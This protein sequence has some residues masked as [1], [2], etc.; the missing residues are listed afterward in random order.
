MNGMKKIIAMFRL[1]RF[2]DNIF[3]VQSYIGRLLFK[4][5]IA[6]IHVAVLNFVMTEGSDVA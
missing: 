1:H 6:T 3:G 4:D 5:C 2:S